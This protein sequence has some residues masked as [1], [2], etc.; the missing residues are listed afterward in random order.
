[1]RCDSDNG[2]SVFSRPI[3]PEDSISGRCRLFGVCLKNFFSPWTFQSCKLMGS[4]TG[5]SWILRE[6]QKGLFYG[7]I[8]LGKSFICLDTG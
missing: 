7:L 6:E 2:D 5:M 8:P 3:I 1:M 4:Q